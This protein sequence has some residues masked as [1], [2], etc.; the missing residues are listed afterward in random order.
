MLTGFILSTGPQ[1]ADMG[2]DLKSGWMVRGRGSDPA[3]EADGR[4]QQFLLQ[5]VGA[6]VGIVLAAAVAGV[7]FR[8]GLIPPMSK[9]FA[10]TAS[11]VLTSAHI[12]VLAGSAVLGAAL[13]LAGG[14]G[15]A[16]GI[17]FA[18]G[19]LIVS[20]WYGVALLA[21]LV[22]RRVI[23]P[24]KMAVRAPGLIAGDGLLHFGEAL[25]RMF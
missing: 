3:R 14:P 8:S 22:V 19:L 5:Q 1:F 10:V 6:I 18:T 17:L 15:K 2:Y 24:E 9:I 16:L 7:Y 25:L 13:Q 23:G 11:M 21:A 4:F 20:P 12:R